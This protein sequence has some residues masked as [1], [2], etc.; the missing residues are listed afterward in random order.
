MSGR[1]TI[2]DVR[3]AGY[4][5]KGIREHCKR[6]GVDFKRL[7]REGIPISEVEGLDDAMAQRIIARAKEREER[8]NG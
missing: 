4:C 5:V 7:V 1:V 8:E 2:S 3:Q 6:V